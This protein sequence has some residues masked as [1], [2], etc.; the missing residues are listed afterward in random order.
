MK[1]TLSEV[2]SINNFL[3]TL[4]INETKFLSLLDELLEN[5]I[6][7]E[8][9]LR[10]KRVVKFIKQYMSTNDWIDSS[11]GIKEYLKDDNIYEI[12]RKLFSTKKIVITDEII[13]YYIKDFNEFF[14]MFAPNTPLSD[15][16][17]TCK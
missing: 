11:M 8:T 14:N 6:I 3:G 16:I 2:D 9:K 10:K 17:Q 15:I 13:A 5:R 12:I 1:T 4:H 7:Q